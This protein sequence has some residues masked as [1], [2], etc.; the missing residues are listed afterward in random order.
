MSRFDLAV[1]DADQMCYAVGFAAKDEPVSHALSTVKKAIN[2]IQKECDA[3]QLQ[4]Y[5]KGEGNFREEVA[6]THGYKANRKE[7]PKPAHY[8]AIMDYLKGKYGAICCDGMEADDVVSIKLYEDFKKAGGDRD[9]ATLILSSPDKDLRNTPGWHH[10]PRTG[11][12][13]WYSD[14]QST[15]HFWYQMLT[16]DNTDNIKGLPKLPYWLCKKYGIAIN[17]VG[18]A[19]AKKLMALTEGVEDCEQFA[20]ELYLH[21][22]QMEGFSPEL[23]KDYVLE[24]AQLLWMVRELDEHNKPVM[25]QINEELY[26]R[27]REAAGLGDTPETGSGSDPYRTTGWETEGFDECNLSIRVSPSGHREGGVS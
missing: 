21:W 8:P 9:K 7:T 23:V 5:V 6:V 17:G 12:I 20:Y 25:F 24:N 10:N 13:V 11:E 22:G 16:G 18:K 14:L 3:E 2:N 15:R 19:G 27:A 26:G 4:L 1:V